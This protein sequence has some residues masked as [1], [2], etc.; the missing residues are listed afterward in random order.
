MGDGKVGVE[1]D[2]RMTEDERRPL[3]SRPFCL[4]PSLALGRKVQMEEAVPIHACLPFSF[5]ANNERTGERERTR[6]PRPAR[7]RAL[8]FSS[9]HREQRVVGCRISPMFI[10]MKG[11]ALPHCDTARRVHISHENQFAS[12]HPHHHARQLSAIEIY[13]CHMSRVCDVLPLKSERTSIAL[14]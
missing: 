12:Q 3:F 6:S 4:G 2:L 14:E 9:P 10:R 7:A 8:N 11:E 1:D 13:R 5:R